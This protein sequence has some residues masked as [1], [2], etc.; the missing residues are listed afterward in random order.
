MNTEEK[1]KFMEWL[2]YE[3]FHNFDKIKYNK[4]YKKNYFIL[5]KSIEYFEKKIEALRS[6][7][8]VYSEKKRIL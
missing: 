2:Y 5:N 8:E 4:W 1:N 7:N 3:A 6:N